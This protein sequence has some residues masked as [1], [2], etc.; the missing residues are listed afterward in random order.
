VAASLGLT[1]QVLRAAPPWAP[2]SD[3]VLPDSFLITDEGAQFV[4][5]N[6][7]GRLS[8]LLRRWS[9]G[10]AHGAR[11]FEFDGSK[12]VERQF[13]LTT[14]TPTCRQPGPAGVPFFSST[15]PAG[16]TGSA[17]GIS[18][19]DLDDDGLQDV[20]VSGDEAGTAV[21]RNAGC[22]FVAVSAG[23]LSTD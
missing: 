18:A 10:A 11:L 23:D 4:D 6:N 3:N 17:F 14:A 9:W 15:R 16:G 22:G 7:S 20:L 1:Q 13:A 12:F 21:F 8:L 19:Y 2:G 5:W